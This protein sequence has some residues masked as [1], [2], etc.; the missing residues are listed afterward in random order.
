VSVSNTHCPTDRRIFPYAVKGQHIV[1]Y[2]PVG[3]VVILPVSDYRW[4]GNDAANF[5]VFMEWWWIDELIPRS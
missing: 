5:V 1:Y 2:W 3:C 4:N